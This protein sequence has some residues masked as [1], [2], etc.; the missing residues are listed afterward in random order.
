MKIKKEAKVSNQN[1]SADT[2]FDRMVSTRK[3]GT[4]N[5]GEDVMRKLGIPDDEKM[6]TDEDDKSDIY[7][8]QMYANML[9]TNKERKLGL[10]PQSLDK[11]EK[12]RKKK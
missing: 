8:K 2:M 9:K 4:Q 10:D 5:S 7:L 12:E 6:S 11:K 3:K 1:P